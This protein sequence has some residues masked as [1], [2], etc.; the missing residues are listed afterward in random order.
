MWSDILPH[1]HVTVCTP[2]KLCL[3]P[4]GL[5]WRRN[6]TKICTRSCWYEIW[7]LPYGHPIQWRRKYSRRMAW[8]LGGIKFHRFYLH[9]W[10]TLQSRS[11]VVS[12]STSKENYS[13]PQVD[14]SHFGRLRGKYFLL[15]ARRAPLCCELF[16]KNT[17]CVFLEMRWPWWKLLWLWW[18]LKM[19]IE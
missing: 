1:L 18:N 19:L 5:T 8:A 11:D 3:F 12:Q 2:R 10:V 9:F 16:S 7:N 13:I 4:I 17:Q 6:K 15:V 14:P